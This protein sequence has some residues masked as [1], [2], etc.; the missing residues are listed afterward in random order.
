MQVDDPRLLLRLTLALLIPSASLESIFHG[1]LGT[2]ISIVAT[3]ALSMPSNLAAV[4]RLLGILLHACSI[5][6]R[7]PL[8]ASRLVSDALARITIPFAHSSSRLACGG[9][10]LITVLSGGIVCSVF[11]PFCFH[12]GRPCGSECSLLARFGAFMLGRIRPQLD[13]PSSIDRN[14]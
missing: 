6:F 9:Q 11:I 10:R 3:I 1:I 12:S 4:S 14:S 5:L 2:A 7:L 8:V 13:G